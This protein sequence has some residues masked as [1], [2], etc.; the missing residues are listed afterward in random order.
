MSLV[1][2]NAYL[3]QARGNELSFALAGRSH[4]KFVHQRVQTKLLKNYFFKFRGIRYLTQKFWI[5][6]NLLYLELSRKFVFEKFRHHPWRDYLEG[7][8]RDWRE[9]IILAASQCNL[10][11][12]QTFASRYTARTCI[13]NKKLATLPPKLCQGRL[14]A[15]TSA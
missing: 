13:C 14:A 10:S 8:E 1:R 2:V 6:R 11:G 3:L 12:S 9:F 5:S 4:F 15:G 7:V